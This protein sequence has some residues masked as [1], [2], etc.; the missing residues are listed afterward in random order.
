MTKEKLYSCVYE[1]NG[2][3]YSVAIYAT[4]KEIE[5]HSANLNLSDIYEITQSDLIMADFTNERLH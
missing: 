4:E 3:A 5:S 2:L 1:C